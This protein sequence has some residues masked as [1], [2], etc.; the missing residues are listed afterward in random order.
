[1]AS[2]QRLNSLSARRGYVPVSNQTRRENEKARYEK[3]W[4]VRMVAD[5][6]NAAG[7]LMDQARELGVPPGSPFYKG[8]QVIVPF[9]GLEAV[10]AFLTAHHVPADDPRW[11]AVASASQSSSRRL[12]ASR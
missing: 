1:M 11:L 2:T 7:S 6:M 10:E 5:D 8:G 4:E 12:S 3:G 9:Y